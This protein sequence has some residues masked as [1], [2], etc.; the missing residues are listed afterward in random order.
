MQE[1]LKEVTIVEHQPHQELVILQAVARKLSSSV[2]LSQSLQLTLS[3]VAELL[4]LETGWIFLLDE[5]GQAFLAAEQNLPAG[6]QIPERMCGSCYCLDIFRMD[7]LQTAENVSMITCSR[8]N[9]LEPSASGDLRFHASIPLQAGGAKLGVMNVASR[10][11]QALSPNELNMLYTIGDLLSL[12]IQRNRYHEEHLRHSALNERY[13]MARELHDSFGQGLAALI[14][15]LET[16]DALTEK[17]ESETQ[18]KLRMQEQI[19]QSVKLARQTLRE[20]RGTV[21][22]LR[23]PELQVG[24]FADDVERLIQE[25]LPDQQVERCIEP[26]A[27]SAQLRHGLYRMVQ[28]LLTNIHR[29]AQAENV[30]IQ[31]DAQVDGVKLV[32]SDD[33]QGFDPKHIPAGHFGLVG[34]R[35]RIHL[36]QGCF[37]LCSQVGQGT[38]VVI[39]LPIQ[40]FIQGAEP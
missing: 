33:G 6:L 20:A 40:G 15:R 9:K 3:Q 7:G 5:Q 25:V 8:L 4:S 35:E 14:M 32:V 17:L 31:L 38:Y 37:K 28:E 2:E 10:Q 29:H 18:L 13:R 1:P 19:Q 26:F 22:N 30:L 39:Q 36:L 12:A 11:K 24:S 21:Q 23:N 16:L 34:L 27:M